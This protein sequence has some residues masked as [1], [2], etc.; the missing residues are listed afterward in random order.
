[1]LSSNPFHRTVEA[2][3]GLV[4]NF[5]TSAKDAP[6]V[7]EKLWDFA[8]SAYLDNPM[9]PSVQGASVRLSLALL[10]GP[11]LHRAP[12]RISGRLRQRRG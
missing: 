6:E 5:F 4:P 2:R 11:L 1:M 12:L 8:T 10:P 9:P 3:F 7:V